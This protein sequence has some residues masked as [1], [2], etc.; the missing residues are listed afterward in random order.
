MLLRPGRTLFSK[1]AAMTLT[2]PTPSVS[3]NPANGTRRPS[4]QLRANGE[5]EEK[6]RDPISVLIVEDDEATSKFL[7]ESM[8]TLGYRVNES[9]STGK[10]ALE[11][12]VR[13]KPDLAVVD[14]RIPDPD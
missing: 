10:K 7:A 3:S 9:A 8:Q 13:N 1:G 2:Q 4:E 11:I 12:A 14:I 5:T 6:P